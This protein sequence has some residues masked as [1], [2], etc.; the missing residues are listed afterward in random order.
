M[1]SFAA[2]VAAAE[3]LSTDPRYADAWLDAEIVNA[4]A[5]AAWE[6]QG[7]LRDWSAQWQQ[8]FRKD[9]IKAMA[10]LKNAGKARL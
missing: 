9:A 8:T 6:E 10:V 3:D 5:M 1:F 7:R 2:F 4:L